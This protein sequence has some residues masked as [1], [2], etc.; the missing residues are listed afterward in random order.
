M[1]KRPN[2]VVFLAD[3]HGAWAMGCAGNRDV[4][5]PNLDA[6]AQQGTR[7]ANFFCVSPVCSPARASLL[8]GRIPSDHGVHDWIRRGCIEDAAGVFR[9]KDRAIGYLDG[10]E[11]FTDYLAGGA[12]AAPCLAN[13]I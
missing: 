7:F 8:T 6:L 3:D 9:G 5:T 12:T 4:M 10:R 11:G 2:I 1:A 13:G